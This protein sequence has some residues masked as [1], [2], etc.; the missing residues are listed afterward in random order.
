MLK[1]DNNIFSR[2]N[3]Q[4][5]LR[6]YLDFY[7]NDFKG[8]VTENVTEVEQ[9]QASSYLEKIRGA[10]GNPCEKVILS[11]QGCVLCKPFV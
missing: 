10:G 4:Q 9:I 8:L 11:C 7:V 3:P 5:Y 1:G 2:D 6:Q